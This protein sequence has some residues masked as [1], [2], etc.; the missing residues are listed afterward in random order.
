[1][2]TP[3]VAPEDSRDRLVTEAMMLSRNWDRGAAPVYRVSEVAKFF[4]CMSASWLRLRLNPD[5]EH[6]NT[7]FTWPDG[8][9]M[10]FRRSDPDTTSSRLFL[11]SDIEPMVDS[12]LKYGMITNDRAVRI[13]DVVRAEAELYRLLDGPEDPGGDDEDEDPDEEAE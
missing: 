3:P 9:R 6:P 5:E 1:M 7:W 10:E 13:L 11:L 2:M 12:L 8:S 4:F